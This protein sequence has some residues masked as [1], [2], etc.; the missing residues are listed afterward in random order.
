[1]GEVGLGVGW[2]IVILVHTIS[3]LN[4]RLEVTA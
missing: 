3:V 2:C 1:M 4:L